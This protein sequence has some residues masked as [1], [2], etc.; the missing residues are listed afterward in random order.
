MKPKQNYDSYKELRKF[1]SSSTEQNAMDLY[2][3]DLSSFSKNPYTYIKSIYFLELST[4]IVFFLRKTG[5][6]PNFFSLL[7]AGSAIVG[8]LL[9]LSSNLYL[10]LL[11]LF[12]L[13]NG[14]VFDWCDGLLARVTNQSSLTGSILDPWSSHSFAL[15][16]KVFL[17]LY[18][19]EHTSSMFFYLVP[20]VVFFNAIDIKTYFQATMFTDL[21]GKTLSIKSKTI[22]D[23]SDNAVTKPDNVRGFLGKY[24]KYVLFVSTFPDDRSRT[25]DLVCLLVLIEHV[26]DLKFVWP[27]FILMVLKELFRFIIN[28]FFVLRTDWCESKVE[29]GVNSR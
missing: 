25:I 7:T 2:D 12:F 21:V 22:S 28:V 1:N 19:A 24:L 8:G 3:I 15:A 29:Q 6:T 18:V 5:I 20:F 26:F 10:L 16:F 23:S 9:I 17:G 14:Y 4:L 27:I 13:F 11:G